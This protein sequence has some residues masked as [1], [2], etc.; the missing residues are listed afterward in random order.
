MADGKSPQSRERYGHLG[1]C[2]CSYCYYCC[3]YSAHPLK[4]QM[5]NVNCRHEVKTALERSQ[6]RMDRILHQEIISPIQL[7]SSPIILNRHRYHFRI[8]LTFASRISN[9]SA[10]LLQS[11]AEPRGSLNISGLGHIS[12]EGSA[13]WNRDCTLQRQCSGIEGGAGSN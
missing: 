12:C 8:F 3:C 1:F 4:G 11:P 2:F 6:A 5:H 7:L 10:S 13:N 9:S